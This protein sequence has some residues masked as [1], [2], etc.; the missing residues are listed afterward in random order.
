VAVAVR[1]RLLHAVPHLSLVL[2][3]VNPIDESGERQHRIG[4][5]S[6]DALPT[7]GHAA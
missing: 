3:H 1:Y 5:H 4:P 6:H 2:V 7:H